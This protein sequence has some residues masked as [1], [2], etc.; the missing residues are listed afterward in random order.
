MTISA[1]SSQ[2]DHVV[3]KIDENQF[4]RN[5]IPFFVLASVL[6]HVIGLGLFAVME[7]SRP[8]VQLIPDTAPI[9]FVVVPPE[10]STASNEIKPLPPEEIPTN[11]VIESEKTV[12]KPKVQ[13]KTRSQAIAVPETIKEDAT[14]KPLKPEKTVVKP[15]TRSQ[16]AAVPEPIVESLPKETQLPTKI[17]E[18][19][20]TKSE[21]TPKTEPSNI[22][23]ENP[24][25]AEIISGS[26][27]AIEEIETPEITKLAKPPIE[28]EEPKQDFLTTRLP[29]KV[30]P[31]QPL[32]TE[33]PVTPAPEP[34]NSSVATRLP[35]NIVPNNPLPTEQPA[36]VPNSSVGTTG[37]ASLLG[38]NL[39]KSFDD[40]GGNSFFNLDNNVS[41]QAYNPSLDAQQRLDM[42]N[43]FSEVRRRVKRNWNPQYSTKDHN[44]VLSFS[45][46]RN[47]E[48]TA[49]QIRQTSGSSARDRE[50]LKAVQNAGPFDPLPANFPLEM[51]KVQ[52]NFN[53]Y[54]Y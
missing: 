9:D 49:L 12:V 17:T 21:P 15:E 6:V 19:K 18:E 5:P 7:R 35:P 29:P 53:I 33:Q 11:K 39:K 43:Y 40:D 26:D 47:G 36:A 46:Q 30:I 32:V 52:F 3:N 1:E 20:I 13:P 23:A 14:P 31:N 28:V 51:L 44:T 50:A 37:A 22:V 10:E 25:S 2:R 4:R 45:I 38:G 27:T 24:N 41:Q 54:T 48:I 16:V 34:E 42:R 8:K